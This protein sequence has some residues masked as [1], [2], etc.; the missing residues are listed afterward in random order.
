MSCI[1][2]SNILQSVKKVQVRI[3]QLYLLMVLFWYRAYKQA[4]SADD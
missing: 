4:T 1:N 2:N 3:M